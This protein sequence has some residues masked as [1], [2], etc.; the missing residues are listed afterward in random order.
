LIQGFLP[1]SVL[2]FIF[3]FIWYEQAFWIYLYTLFVG[4][5]SWLYQR[6]FKAWNLNESLFLRKGILGEEFVLINWYKLQT[7]VIQQS[8]YQR[9]KGLAT[10]VINSASGALKLPYIPLK[11][12]SN[13]LTTH[14]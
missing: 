5:H 10:V 9:K 6:K 1:A 14:L 7:V 12:A 11:K 2:V 3:W 4:L 8:I 13:L